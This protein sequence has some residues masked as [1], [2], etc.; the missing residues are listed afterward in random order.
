MLNNLIGATLESPTARNKA[1]SPVT[2]ICV[3]LRFY[4]CGS[5]QN[6]LGDTLHISQPSTSRIITAVTEALVNVAGNFIKFPMAP[7]EIKT[8]ASDFFTLLRCTIPS[9]VGCVDGTHVRIQAPV[10]NEE[11]YVNRKGYHSL[12]VQLVCSAD[13][14]ILNV[15]SKWPGSVHD[16]TIIRSS[17]L[18]GHM[19]SANNGLNGILLG[20]SGYACK[21]FLLTPFR[22]PA[23]GKEER[24]NR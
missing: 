24:Y 9:V 7:E 19:Q 18:W 20:D 11:A 4:A 13:S 8:A 6:V 5:Y 21:R 10:V 2:K 22:A 23:A 16:S 3:A 17:A 12:N 15:V 1:I 14:R